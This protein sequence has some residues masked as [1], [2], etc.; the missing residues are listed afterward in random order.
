VN[1]QPNDFSELWFR[2]FL[3]TIDPAQTAVELA[4]LERVL[5]LERHRRILDLC[6]GSG[7]HAL[8]L[9]QAGYLVTGIDRNAALLGRARE[10]GGPRA[11]FIEMDMRRLADL[12]QQ[13]DAII[14]MWAS[15]GYFGAQENEQLLADMR[16][17]LAWGGRLVLDVYNHDFY[18]LR[19]GQRR[20]ER[21][22]QEVIEQMQVT[23]DR[24]NVELRYSGHDV[25]DRFSWQVFRPSDV[26]DLARALGFE[27][28]VLC[29]A[30]DETQ[31]VSPAHGRMQLVWA[32]A[33]SDAP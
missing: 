29:T 8:P 10:A 30:F 32:R 4:F 16:A 12:E 21:S 3:D 14:S 26:R 11:T 28:L 18:E 24:V 17:C 22:G 23:G 15:I 19:Q 27:P 20:L 5:P 7:R 9:A 6:C 31:T 25:I 1:V 2:T 33:D 13:W